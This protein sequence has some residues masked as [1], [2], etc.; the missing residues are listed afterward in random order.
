MEKWT[1]LLLVLALVL[2]C[3]SRTHAE[4]RN[5]LKDP[6]ICGRPQCKELNNKFKYKNHTLYKYDYA[7]YVKTEFSGSGENSSELHLIAAVQIEF[8]KPCQ[9]LLKL[10]SIEVRDRPLPVV[11]EQDFEY[12]A[13][14][15]EPPPD[16]G[17]HPKSETIADELTRFELKFAFHDGIVSEICYETDEPVWTL[18]LKR[19]ILSSFQNSMPR[20]DIDYHTTE[21]D[22]SGVCDVAYTISGTND[23]KLM[24]T[25]TKDITSCK[26][27]YKTNSFIQTVPYDF[28]PDYVAWPLLNSTSYCSISVD[29]FIYSEVECFERHQLVPFSNQ[30][31]GAVTKVYS[32]LAFADTESYSPEEHNDDEYEIQKRST[33]IYDHTP[34]ARDS[35]DEIKASREILKELCRSGFPDIRR[36]FPDVFL[37]FLSTTRVLSFTALSQLLYRSKSICD[38]GRNHV[39][40]SLPYIGS[41]ASVTLMKDQIVKQQIPNDLARQWLDSFACLTRPN[42]E[43]LE[44]MLEL[45]EHGKNIGEKEFIL[46]ATSVA[47]TFC[48]VH[49]DCTN[50]EGIQAIVHLL[51][52][53]LIEQL[54]STAE[55]TR[56]QRENILVILKG[57]GNM[58][59]INAEYY[60]VLRKIIENE[61]LPNEIRLQAVYA[62]RR[63]DCIRTRDYFLKLYSNFENDIEI[64]I[65]A[66]QQ[67]MRC[68][69]YLSI[70]LIKYMLKIE[71]VNQVGSYV[72]SHLSNLAKSASPVQVE[73]QGLLADND[74]GKRFQMDIRKFSRN[75]EHTLFFDDYNFGVATDANLIFSTDSYLPKT[76]SLNLT[77]D[78][79]GESVN[80]LE[81]NARTEGFEYLVESIF[82]PTGP[83]NSKKI[84]EYTATVSSLFNSESEEDEQ[85]GY[86]PTGHMRTRRESGDSGE[87]TFEEDEI[88]TREKRE[89]TRSPVII[90]RDIH[91]QIDD[92]GYKMRT[93]FKDPHASLGIKIFGNDLKYYTIEGF[94]ETMMAA[95]KINP[96]A[97]LRQLLSGKEISYTKSGVIL[98]TSYDV[99]LSVGLPLALSVVGASSV[100]LR[101]AGSFK[102]ADVFSPKRHIDVEGKIKPSI[103]VDITATM[104]TDFIHTATGIK[105][106]S[107]LYSSSALEAKLKVR[108]DRLASLQFSLPQDHNEIF[109]VRSEMLV[110]HDSKEIHQKGIE[111]R[112]SNS[113]CTWP[114]ID[115]A[116]GLKLCADYSLPDVSNNTEVPSL[117]LSG[118]VNMDISLQKA[119]PTAKV[120]LFQYAWDSQQNSSSGS[121]IFETP[122][123]QIPR[124]FIANISA[125]PEGYS[126]S[127]G[128]RNGDTSHSAIGIYK[129]NKDQR[130]LDMSLNV[131]DRKYL[132]L[133]MGYNKTEIKY[134]M[135]YSPTLFL[136]VNNDRIAGMAGQIKMTDKKGIKQWDYSL[137]F[138]TKR[139]QTKILGYIQ[140]TQAS[141]TSKL[142]MDY[143]FINGK[144]ERLTLGGTL[145]NRSNRGR[146]EYHGSFDLRSTAYPYFDFASNLKFLSAMGHI[147]CKV[148]YNNAPDLK[149]PNY[150][151]TLRLIFARFHVPDS[152]RTK[153]SVELTRPRSRMDFK[154]M[155][156]HENNIKKGTEHN[157]LMLLRYATN[158]EVTAVFSVYLPRGVLFAIDTAANITVPGFDSCTIHF[159]VTEKIRKEYYFDITGMWFSGHSITINGWYEDRSSFIKT[160][161]HIKMDAQSP[162]F[163]DLTADVKYVRDEIEYK[164]EANAEYGKQPYGITVKHSRELE[165][166]TNTY[167][168]F[169]WRDSLYWV[170]AV[171]NSAPIKQL[172]LEVHIDK[173]RDISVTLK[174]YSTDRKREAGVEIKWDANRDPTQ[175]I[176]ITGE[177]NTPKYRIFNGR[178]LVAYPNRT[179]SGV[180][181]LKAIDPNYMANARI[182]WNTTETIEL[183]LDAGSD[184]EILRNMWLLFKLTTPFEGWRYNALNGGFYFKDNLLK[185]NISANWAED[186]I[187]GLEVMG[188]YQ[189]NDSDFNCEM[190]TKLHSSIPHVPTVKVH[191]KHKYDIKRVDTVVTVNHTVTDEPPQVFSVRSAWQYDH[192][193]MYRN[194][195]GKLALMSPFEGYKMGALST[196]FSLSESRELQGAA[197][198]QLDEDKYE[199]VLRGHVRNLVDNM[200]TVNVTSSNE[201]FRNINGRVGISEKD[202]YV[203]AEIITPR[204]ALGVEILFALVSAYDFDVKFYLATPLKDFERV[205]LRGKLKPDNV[206]FRIGLNKMIIGFVGVWRK[207]HLKNFEYSYKVFSPLPKFEENGIILKLIINEENSEYFDLEFGGRLSQYK[208]G[209][210]AV[211]EPKQRLLQ[212]LGV[213]K[214]FEI[215]DEF[216]EESPSSREMDLDEEEDEEEEDEENLMN[217]VGTVEI[218][219]IVWPTITGSVD[220]E[221]HNS[222]YYISGMINLPQGQ[223]DIHDRF[224]L[225]DLMNMKNLLK[226]KTPFPFMKEIQS[227]FELRIPYPTNKFVVGFN[228]LVLNETEWVNSG[229]HIYYNV[230]DDESDTKTH[231][232]IVNLMTPMNNLK[233]VRLHGVLDIEEHG[234]KGNLTA[235]T[236]TTEASMA[237]GFESEDQ[238]IDSTLSIWVQAP[239][240]P[241][242]ACRVFY[243][244]DFAG[245]DNLM[246]I[247]FAVIEGDQHNHL[248]VDGVWSTAAP[249][250]LV[251]KG[252]YRSNILPLEMIDSEFVVTRDPYPKAQFELRY[253]HSDGHLQHVRAT[254]S[255]NREMF[256]IELSIPMH[257]YQN[258]SLYGRLLKKRGNE[259]S[260]AGQFYRNE[261]VF[262]VDGDAVIIEDI[263]KNVALNLKPV[264]GGEEGS[265][266]YAYSVT[267]DVTSFQ[268]KFERGNK[269]TN[270]D[271]SFKFSSLADW[272]IGVDSKSSESELNDID[273]KVGISPS[274]NDNALGKLKL[275]TPWKRYGI[276]RIDVIIL[277]DVHPISG[278]VMANYSIPP[279]NGDASCMWNWHL[280]ENM[281]FKLRNRVRRDSVERYFQTGIRYLHPDL[282]SNHNMTFGGDLNLNN[283]WVFSANVSANLISISDLSG[284]I[285]V[286][287]PNPVGDV[288]K[289]AASMKGNIPFL[290]NVRTFNFESSYETEESRKRYAWRSEY[291]RVN[292]LRTLFRFE[293]GPDVRSEQVQSN[294]DVIKNGEKH[295]ISAKLRGP[296]YTEDAFHALAVYSN[297]DNLFLVN[298]NVSMPASRKVAEANVAFANLSNMK[299]DVNCTTPFL[300]VTWLHGQLEFIESPL[301]SIRYLKATWPESSAILD[302]KTTYSSSPHN[303]DRE[304]Q[305]TIKIEI[306]LQTRHYAEVKYG[307][308]ERP[309]ITTGHAEIDYNNRQVLRGQYTSKQESRAGHERETVDVILEN[310]FKP[311]GVHYVHTKLYKDA[312]REIDTKRAE[313]F[314]LRN[315]QKFNITGELQITSRDTGREYIIT[316]IHPNRTVVLTADYDEKGDTIKQRSKLQL[317]PKRWIAYDIHLTNLSKADNISQNFRLDISYPRRNLSAGGWYM[318][319]DNAFDSKISLH[320]TPN[321]TAY[322]DDVSERTLQGALRWVDESVSNATKHSFV[323]LLGHPSF[324]QD[325]TLEGVYYSDENDLLKTNVDVRY[326][327]ADDHHLLVGF[328]A[329]DLTRMV[330]YRNYSYHGYGQ[331]EA[332]SLDFDSVGSI[333]LRLGLYEINSNSHYKRGYL[334]QMEGVVVGRM[335]VKKREILLEKMTSHSNY[336]LWGKASGNYP[337]YMVN[338]S[339]LDGQ[340]QDSA[341]FFLIDIDEKLVEMKVNMTPDA[342]ENIYMYGIIPDSR[343]A[344]FDFWRD[345]D[346][347]REVDVAYYLKMNHSRLVTSKLHWRPEIRSD[348]RNLLRNYF[349]SMHNSFTESLEFW[350]KQFYLES[351][352]S[353][354][355]VWESAHPYIEGFLD[356]VSGLNVIQ[357]D[358]EDLRQFLNASYV[359]DDFYIR[360][361]INFTVT[362]LDELAIKNKITSLPKIITE[363]WQVMGDSGQA[364]KKSVTWLMETI[365]V[366]YQKLVDVIGRILQGD[367][368]RYLSEV[369]ENSVARYDKFIK[370]VHLQFIK[371]VQELWNK[372][373]ELITSYWQRMLMNIEPSVIKLAHYVESLTWHVGHEVFTFLY[374]KTQE[375]AESPYFT[376]V[377]N[378]TQDLDTLYKDLVQNDIITNTKKYGAIVIRFVKEKF[379]RLVPF[380]RE[381]SQVT[382]ELWEEIKQLQKLEYVQFIMQHVNDIRAKI[383]W[384]AE[385]FQLEKRLHQLLRI[386]KNKLTKYAQTALQAENRY[387]EAKTKF[388]FDPDQGILEL[389][390]K[391][392]MSWHA[393][394]ETPKFEE[395]PEYRFVGDI[396]DFFTGSN[397]TIWSLYSG[398]RHYTDPKMW[399]PPFKANS[400]LVGARHYMSFDRRFVSIDLS[401]SN[402]YG[403]VK[404]CSYVLAHDFYNRTFTLLLEPSVQEKGGKMSRIIT[405][406][407][408]DNLLEIDIFD[409]SVKIGRNVTTALPAQIGDT[410]VYREADLLTVKSFRGFQLTC[411]L[412]YH[413]C[414]FDLSGWYFGKI[415]G[416]LGTMNNE[417]FD[418][419]ITSDRQYASSKEQF[420]NS[421]KLPGCETNVETTNHTSNYFSSSNELSQLCESF[422]R[423]KHSYFASCFPIVDSTPFFEMCL[424]LGLH[425]EAKAN[426]PSNNGACTSALAYMEACSLEDM[427]L[428]V[429]DTCIHCKLINGSY[430]PEGTFV[431]IKDDEIP[432]TTDIV[433]IIE[434]KPCN[435]N[436]TTSKSIMT[437]VQSLHKELLELNITENRYS[438]LSFGGASPFDKPRSVTVNDNVFVSHEFIEPFFN[439]ITTSPGTNDD[440]FDA[441]IVASKLV[442]RPGAS[443]T[444]ILMPC[445]RC[446]SSSM[447][448]DYSSLLQLMLE[449][450]IKLHILT[451][452]DIEFDKSRV[453]RMFFGM[454]RDKAYTKKDLKD[455][456]GDADLRKQVRLPKATLGSCAALALETD[457]SVFSGRKLRPE[458]RNPTKK[459]ITVFTKRVALTAAPNACQTCECTGHNTG[460]SYMLCLPC[461][462]PSAFSLDHE[463]MSEDELLSVLQPDHDWD[464]EE[465]DELL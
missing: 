341:G 109:S 34:S 46:A 219:T 294:F 286:H 461:S 378:F 389:E 393:F 299:G 382:T 327:H 119:D 324:E 67:S 303:L 27:R 53:D 345:Y 233:K 148:E 428:R 45:V 419:S 103:S 353:V 358:L 326:T 346:T 422:F 220:L 142:S 436:I 87:Y 352:E 287:L 1:R 372:L 180:F 446:A 252:K 374:N 150:T 173:L 272:N 444:F 42:E 205:L 177:L 259:Y 381:L 144:L 316:A 397:T 394:N 143:R 40:D 56:R 138:E 292:D 322:E 308:A 159:R 17:Q 282:E 140:Q 35:H 184:E 158:K 371:N 336:R 57:L 438:V 39:L 153:A 29:D 404:Q 383:E 365:R 139:V 462:Y 261:E 3:C 10:N 47:H 369:L 363:F 445:S 128:F 19:G 351:K 84:K 190:K 413:M 296:W 355:G 145:A 239:L 463:R 290:E 155:I 102:A 270:L 93:D 232:A 415:A 163:G 366:S 314:E 182:S 124:I 105:V 298:G 305:G 222:K 335:D 236:S 390:Q 216:L 320:Y 235:K 166:G 228:V 451:D 172:V 250:F 433:F 107:N 434:A 24:I 117:I 28:R 271:G 127:M 7:M 111:R 285:R 465:D 302:A 196:K 452:Q 55:L 448:L 120:F 330:R 204:S 399:L 332:S 197:D 98:D 116:I 36:N 201:K 193:E 200:L 307:L 79:F 176:A 21:T 414:S 342:S 455:V 96:L 319:T 95:E 171:M 310:D 16:V 82:G 106:K 274:D 373:S 379:F 189:S 391:L 464:W 386:A 441:I 454:D 412:Q 121:I 108:G 273:L 181:D 130:W 258:M 249:H 152:G 354:N 69:D 318:V 409:T 25:K 255:R 430:V 125:D 71:E 76:A 147:E 192:D 437:M 211:S 123:S 396:Q 86:D 68:P 459:F 137:Q 168:G 245:S 72:W 384:L 281:Q 360:S 8:T 43:V 6:R 377:S 265:I 329:R 208:L 449:N 421:W 101:M 275:R 431:P 206:D 450:G 187:L 460:V 429:P 400:L 154:A 362:V 268:A 58:G 110:F 315:K 48:T 199:L 97:K 161:H 344:Y 115:R 85:A 256:T 20:F 279:I 83:L 337:V 416:I 99:P 427:P 361:V 266:T 213:Q 333:G 347:S 426:D 185:T 194:I 11:P 49:V 367:S 214:A 225:E 112:Y 289:L 439:H 37:N 66:Y 423:Q 170:S 183:K 118:P 195:S 447:K 65:A 157:V 357:D 14:Y 41:P 26:K 398:L 175:K 60:H 114:V 80:F 217:L 425:L 238:F 122:N 348:V 207:Q 376:K 262:N 395:I 23:T 443:K 62:F 264:G 370:D 178:F 12:G 331:H 297:D 263:P 368:M 334:S 453:S 276:E 417:A 288:H 283:I 364:L 295:E 31:A 198:L 306:P 403:D 224:W 88:R 313:V 254:A 50:S 33:L 54:A 133:E 162:S 188:L 359:A 75:Y 420:I 328:N 291:D 418:D 44:A 284:I 338:G 18:N 253:N 388:I 223:V 135:I 174:G 241:Y 230:T 237:L 424:D 131:N 309:A 136:S 146:T 312:E 167:A 51:E 401:D 227:G 234:Y 456:V 440:I 70:K 32:R 212:Q 9:G 311:V 392:P 231:H 81:L 59:V 13:D 267:N 126:V 339:L 248:R 321:K 349:S 61:A 304:Q 209:L 210:K 113:T 244:Q 179:V 387:R 411:S 2:Y 408:E 269:N 350:V 410:V 458:R 257:E 432:Q 385:E 141:I 134:G 90:S 246:D 402:E 4:K 156:K 243:K 74:I 340:E 343:S 221:E 293:W 215:I 149:D 94:A 323:V 218:D 169:K 442:F 5:P 407:S 406:V 242:Y 104:K 300:N 405:L 165:N 203:V 92:M 38:N 64:R 91:E 278:A 280:L 435:H 380:G 63:H 301:E 202:R 73:A 129:N 457:G 77:A 78:V 132:A 356:D 151:T 191:L 251:G 240:V 325:V 15:E 22:V 375:I 226:V 229:F 89:D 30:N 164:L 317:S 160:Y 52:T 260:V 100:D 277:F 247:G 186:Q